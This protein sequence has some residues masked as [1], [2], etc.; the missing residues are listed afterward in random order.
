LHY[1]SVKFIMHISSNAS[2][3]VTNINCMIMHRVMFE[4]QHFLLSVVRFVK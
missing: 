2:I 3:L 4:N 1:S